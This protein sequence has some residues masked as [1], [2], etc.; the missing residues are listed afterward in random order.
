MAQPPLLREGG[1]SAVAQPF[2]SFWTVPAQEGNSRS[3]LKTVRARRTGVNLK[4]ATVLITGGSS[5]IGLA[6]AK[7]LAGAGARVAVTGRDEHKLATA[8]RALNVPATRT[9]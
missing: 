2:F 4:G 8:A 9:V 1:D 6:T 5:G 7:M 3:L